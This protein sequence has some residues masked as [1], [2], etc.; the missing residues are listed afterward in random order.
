MIGP[1]IDADAQSKISAMIAQG[2][3]DATLAW[4]ATL[5][6]AVTA[7]GGFYV[8]P[9]IFTDVK[10]GRGDRTREIFGPCWP[11]SRCATSTRRSRSRTRPTTPDGRT[12]LPQPSALRGAKGELTV[13]TFISTAASPARSSSGIRLAASG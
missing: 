9:A 8:A 3:R 2:R 6:A 11:C 5:P 1:V 4:Q 7:S 10:A 12:L 13:G